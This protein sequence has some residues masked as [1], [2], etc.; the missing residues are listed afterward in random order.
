[1]EKSNPVEPAGES[2]RPRWKPGVGCL[3]AAL[4]AVFF[5][6]GVAMFVAVAMSR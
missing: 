2:E 5:A 3:V 4:F 6:A 1:M